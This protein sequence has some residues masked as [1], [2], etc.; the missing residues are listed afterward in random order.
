MSTIS[1]LNTDAG[2]SGKTIQDLES[3]QT[4]TGQ[5]SFNR[6][7]S[8]PFV[9]QSGSAKVSNLDADKADG[10]DFDQSVLTTGTPSFAGLTSTGTLAVNGASTLTG[11]VTAP[12]SVIS[13][14]GVNYTLP[15]AD[16]AANTVLLTDGAGTLSW[17]ASNDS[18]YIATLSNVLNTASI[19]TFCSFT[20]PS[21]ADGDVIEVILSALKKNN[22]GTSGTATITCAYGAATATIGS[23]ITW[24]NSATEFNDIYRVTLMRVGSDLWVTQPTLSPDSSALN[25]GVSNISIVSA[26]TFGSSQTVALKLTLSAA[27]ATFYWKPQGARIRHKK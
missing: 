5:K 13:L 16:G 15:A 4:V 25:D 6:S 20:V 18:A 26:P 19:T 23:G 11:K 3:T 27:D 1:V 7:P 12:N 17:A 9:V 22:K 8:A 2:L 21:M 24:S 10:Y 14:R